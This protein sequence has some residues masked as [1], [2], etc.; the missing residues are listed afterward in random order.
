MDYLIDYL[1]LFAEIIVVEK[2]TL[3]VVGTKVCNVTCIN[4]EEDYDVVVIK[5]VKN[6]TEV[7]LKN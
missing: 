3:F 4:V 6:K 5:K 1:L 2:E 7:E